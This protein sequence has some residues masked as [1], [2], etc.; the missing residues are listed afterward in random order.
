M[1]VSRAGRPFRQARFS[2][3]DASALICTSYSRYLARAAAARPALAEQ[4]AV[5]AAA[6]LARAQQD[7]RLTELLGTPAAGA[8]APT[9]EQLK[10]ALRQLRAEVFGAVAE[11]DLRGLA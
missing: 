6:P 11:R 4:I 3:T 1:C 10:R 2:M 9:E 8:A 7:A 5:W